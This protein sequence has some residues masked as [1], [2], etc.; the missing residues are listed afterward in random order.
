MT[1]MAKVVS[2]PKENNIF[3]DGIM[4]TSKWSSGGMHTTLKYYI[5]EMETI[6]PQSGD[7]FWAYDMG[8]TETPTIWSIMQTIESFCNITFSITDRIEEASIVWSRSDLEGNSPTGNDLGMADFPGERNVNGETHGEAQSLIVIN[9]DAYLSS[10]YNPAVTDPDRVVQGGYNYCTFIHELGHA[11]GLT[12]PH[13]SGN[14]SD[15]FPGVENPDDYGNYNKNQGIYTMM[16]YNDGWHTAPHKGSPSTHWGYQGGPMALDI[17]ALQRMYGANTNYQTGNDTYTLRD[18]NQI[19]TFY[20]CIWDA[21]GTDLIQ[22]TKNLVNIIDLRAATLAYD[23]GGGGYVSYAKGIHGGFTIA[24]GVLIENATGG[25]MNDKITGNNANNILKGLGGNDR[26]YGLAGR[27]RLEGGSG[28]D[29]LDGGNG[30]DTLVGGAGNDLYVV[31]AGDVVI[32]AARQ[33]TDTIQSMGKWVLGA[34]LENLVLTGARHVNGTGNG[35]ANTLTGNAG[36]NVLKGLGGNDRLAGGAGRDTLDGGAGNDTLI[37]GAG[38]DRL[39]GGK[40]ADQLE[41]SIGNDVLIG[42]A[43]NDRLLG[44]TGADTLEGG[45]GRDLLYGGADSARDVFVFRSLADSRPGA[46]NRDQLFDF[47]PG[48]DDIDL[49]ALDADSGRRGNQDFDFSGVTAAA[50][51]VWYVKQK[52]GVLVRA[53]HDGDAKA[54]FEIWVGDVARLGMGDFIF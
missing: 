42:G 46:A 41:G 25:G 15:Q 19:G 11:L 54:D 44:G 1:D 35:L 24:E 9:A 23:V 43:G 33:G 28:N 21:G 22:G 50:N 48:R 13:D 3:L 39:L 29:M 31:T 38:N 10:K 36:N 32:E 18:T 47:R 4:G 8:P 40:G 12:H 52:G 14:D 20:S 45:A 49:S 16:S 27:D 26:L 7:R 51:S 37:G 53:D 2:V 5:A 6:Y 30:I 17:A 34:N